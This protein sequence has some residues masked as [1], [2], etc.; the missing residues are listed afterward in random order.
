MAM[1]LV[2]VSLITGG[3]LF[4]YSQIKQTLTQHALKSELTQ[5][6][7]EQIELLIPSILVPEQRSGLSVLL[8][9]FRSQESLESIDWVQDAAESRLSIGCS[10]V[11]TNSRGPVTCLSPDKSALT[12]FA[13]IVES[14]HSYGYLVK[15]KR[16]PNPFKDDHLLDLIEISAGVLLLAF[17]LLFALVSKLTTHDLPHEL[18]ALVTWVESVLSEETC[19]HAPPSHIQEVAKLGS[20]IAD[21]LE[22][23]ERSRDQ[24][25]I[26]QLTSGIVHD[27]KESVHSIVNAQQL[28]EE[29]PNESPKRPSRLENL[30]KVCRRNLPE[31]GDLVESVLDGNREIH[32]EPENLDLSRAIDIAVKRHEEMAKMRGLTIEIQTAGS[33]ELVPHDPVQV[34]RVISNFVKNGL[35]SASEAKGEGKDFLGIRISVQGGPKKVRLAVEDTGKGFSGSVK[36]NPDKVF[37]IFRSSK[38]RGYGLGLFVS[39]K[40][41]EAHRGMITA[42][43]SP[44]L[45]GARFEFELSKDVLKG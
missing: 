36:A 4:G 18:D 41:I 24:A 37:R 32:L 30:L 1:V 42:G 21:V 22:R 20:Q 25:M 3:V 12:I 35:E 11:N 6:T 10:G 5:S 26:G 14:G 43:S 2:T 8:N 31:I 9:R 7:A 19:T 29:L 17:I 38:P 33:S 34:S 27:L 40:I 23:H 45:G 39:K 13:P 28:V 15:S 16:V 44:E